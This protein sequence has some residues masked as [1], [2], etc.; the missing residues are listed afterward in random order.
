M[1]YTCKVKDKG[2]NLTYGSLY[3]KTKIKILFIDF[4]IPY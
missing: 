4:K 1:Q 3:Q 2:E